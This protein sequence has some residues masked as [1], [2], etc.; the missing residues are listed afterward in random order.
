MIIL[1]RV[2]CSFQCGVINMIAAFCSA[3]L[4]SLLVEDAGHLFKQNP[5]LSFNL[6]EFN[7]ISKNNGLGKSI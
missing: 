6:C 1:A 7:Y 2:S 5:V 3:R 4:L